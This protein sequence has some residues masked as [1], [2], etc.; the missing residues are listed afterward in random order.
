M[1]REGFVVVGRQKVT[2][3]E[4]IPE[5]PIHNSFVALQQDKEMYGCCVNNNEGR[6]SGEVNNN[7]H[8]NRVDRNS[9]GEKSGEVNNNNHDNSVICN[10]GGVQ[11]SNIG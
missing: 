4:V 3:V 10:S 9:G 8:G 1:D 2:T 6:S 11:Q 5:I 7:D